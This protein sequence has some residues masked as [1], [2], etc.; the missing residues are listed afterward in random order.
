[1]RCDSSRRNSAAAAGVV[2]I[3]AGVGIAAFSSHLR[4]VEKK[5]DSGCQNLKP[6]SRTFVT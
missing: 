3:A 5:I 4:I 1:M 6:Q 2:D